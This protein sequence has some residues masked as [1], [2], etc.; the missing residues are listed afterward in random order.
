M[1]PMTTFLCRVQG[2]G[3]VYVYRS[4]DFVTDVLLAISLLSTI[5]TP[6]S[7]FGEV[8]P[9]CSILWKMRNSMFDPWRIHDSV[10]ATCEF[11]VWDLY[12]AISHAIVRE[13]MTQVSTCREFITQLPICPRHT[14]H[15]GYRRA[16]WRRVWGS[17][18]PSKLQGFPHGPITLVWL[19]IYIYVCI[20]IMWDSGFQTSEGALLGWRMV[21]S[22]CRCVLSS[23]V[24]CDWVLGICHVGLFV[25]GYFVPGHLLIG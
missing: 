21:S 2:S 14:V 11:T 16:D 1:N 10:V 18:A 23:D 4:I 15:Q 5:K 22:C 6:C 9:W 25:F 7:T 24:Y 19:C 13:C 8:I 3:S 12:S 17:V 20:Q